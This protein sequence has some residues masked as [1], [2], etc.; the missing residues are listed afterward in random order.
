MGDI[1]WG[2]VAATVGAAGLTALSW[3]AATAV[4]VP[5]AILGVN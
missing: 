4:D 2:E 1:D 3:T 5:A